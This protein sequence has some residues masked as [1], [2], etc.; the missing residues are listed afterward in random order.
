MRCPLCIIASLAREKLGSGQLP[1][2]LPEA[3]NSRPSASRLFL[4]RGC[5]GCARLL[6]SHR[7]IRID[8]TGNLLIIRQGAGGNLV[9]VDIINVIGYL[10]TWR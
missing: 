6:G 9:T 4:L 1:N 10:L 2:I 3:A 8:H 7:G 5:G